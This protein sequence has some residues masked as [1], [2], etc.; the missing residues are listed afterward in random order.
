MDFFEKTPFSYPEGKPK[1]SK[2]ININFKGLSRILLGLSRNC[3]GIFLNA[4]G[5]FIYVLPCSPEKTGA[6]KIL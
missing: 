2:H 3:P 6:N 5:M 1:T 4:S